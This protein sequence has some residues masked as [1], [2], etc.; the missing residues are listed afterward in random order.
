MSSGKD[1]ELPRGACAL[2]IEDNLLLIGGSVGDDNQLI[3]TSTLVYNGSSETWYRVDGFPTKPRHQVDC[4]ADKRANRILVY[5]GNRFR[6]SAVLY[7]KLLY[8]KGL[9]LFSL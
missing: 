9:L 6:K 1:V 5:G 7:H 2:V 8:I 3:L 4:L